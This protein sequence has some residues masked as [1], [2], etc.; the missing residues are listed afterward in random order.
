MGLA[1]VTGA[2]GH[3]GANVVR[4]LVDAGRAVRCLVRADVRALEGLPVERAVGDLEDVASLQKAFAGSQTV[5][6]LAATVS[7]AGGLGGQVERS[8]VGGVQN[9]LEAC[10]AAGVRRLVHFSSVRAMTEPPEGTPL[11]EDAPLASGRGL[12]AYERSKVDGERLVL[13]AVAGGF[14]AVIC[15][16][17]AAIGPW[18][19]KPSRAGSA[20]LD[21]WRGR[22]PALL[23][24]GFDWVDA[25]DVA[26][27]ALAAEAKGTAGQR[28]LLSGT[29]RSLSG[30]AALVHQAGGRPPPRL[31][32]PLVLASAVAPLG[33][34]GARLLG[35]TPVFTPEAV[36]ALAGRQKIHPRRSV[37]DL[38]WA[39]RPLEATV[40]DTL[41]WFRGQGVL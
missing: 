19:Y 18:D 14:D 23:D 35:A 12:S 32:V 13:E 22:L 40:A 29:W 8:N 38:G 4:A 27:G 30:I 3:L 39:P 10:R 15:T 7:V 36:R 34:A 37:A 11:D 33:L 25:R 21:L 31:V 6:H 17:T 41:A 16:P 20:L 28:Y 1:V 9:V 24:G 26:Q 5:F 2:A